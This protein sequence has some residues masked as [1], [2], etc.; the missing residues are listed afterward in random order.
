VR[1]ERLGDPLDLLA[2]DELAVAAHH[3][4]L[5]VGH[6]VRAVEQRDD[7]EE[8]PGEQDDRV[9]VARRVAQRDA[10]PSLVLDREGVDVAQPRR[11]LGHR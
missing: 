7:L 2:G 4:R 9:G 11:E 3:R 8:H 1:V 5:D 6:R 10:G